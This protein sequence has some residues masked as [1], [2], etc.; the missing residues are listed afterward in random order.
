MADGDIEMP[1][2][3]AWVGTLAVGQE[4]PQSSESHLFQ[5]AGAYGEAS[6]Q[7][8]GLCGSLGSVGAGVLESVDGR[9]A[10]GFRDFVTQLES[11]APGLV[12]A[13]NQL[14]D[15]SDQTAVQ[16]EYTKLM[17]IVQ[18]VLLAL[19]ILHYLF[20]APEAIPAAVTG[21]RAVVLMLLK[22]LV[23]GVAVGTALGV[24]SDVLVQL[25]QFISGHRKQWDAQ[26]TA[27]A[28]ESGAVSGGTSG[29]VFG[30]GRLAAPKFAGSLAGNV[31]H[32]AISG[33][34]SSV[35]MSAID[36]DF[37]DVATW[38]GSFTSGLAGGLEGGKK[39]RFGKGG[40]GSGRVNTDV[41][42]LAGL[43]A[44]GLGLAASG[45]A[46]MDPAGFA[47]K[48]DMFGM[49]S[50]LTASHTATAGTTAR[51]GAGRGA[52]AGAG[53]GRTVGAGAQGT[54]TQGT[55]QVRTSASRGTTPGAGREGGATGAREAVSGI[56]ATA[57]TSGTASSFGAVGVR[58]AA[59]SGAVASVRTT[60][61]TGGGTGTGGGA[62][63]GPGSAATGANRPATT[64]GDAAAAAEQGHTTGTTRAGSAMRTASGPAAAVATSAGS[65]A[66]ATSREA[67][68]AQPR[69]GGTETGATARALQPP[70]AAA[71]VDPVPRP[72]PEAEPVPQSDGG[73]FVPLPASAAVPG[74]VVSHV[75]SFGSQDATGLDAGAAD[76]LRELAAHVARTADLRARTGAPLPEITI[77]GHG[78]S[79]VAGQPHFGQALQLGAERARQTYD[80]LAQH[81]DHH[82]AALGSPLRAD[83]L[84]IHQRSLGPALPHGTD[85]AHDTPQARRRTVITLTHTADDNPPP[86]RTTPLSIENDLPERVN[87]HLTDHLS[88]EPVPDERA[89]E[90][91]R[92]LHRTAGPAF[93]RMDFTARAEAVARHLAKIEFSGTKGGAR[94]EALGR[95]A[96]EG[97]SGSAGASG[98]RRPA[99][100]PPASHLLPVGEQLDRRRPPEVDHGAPPPPVVTGAVRFSDG[101]RIPAYMTG[102]LSEQIGAD[103][104]ALGAGQHEV[105]GADLAVAELADWFGRVAGVRPAHPE[106][107]LDL[108]GRGLR[109]DLREFLGEVKSFPYRTADGLPVHL[110]LTA[111]S[112]GN[113]ERFTFGL[114]SPTKLDVMQRSSA[115]SGRV[116]VNGT[117]WGIAPTLPLALA[118]LPAGGWGRAYL[119]FSFSKQARF[120]LQ[121]QLTNQ[122]ETRSTDGA[123]V[124][125]DDLG[126]EFH[127]VDRLGRPLGADGTPIAE[128]STDR[129]PERLRFAV[130]DGLMARL[131]ASLTSAAPE[132][133]SGFPGT[134]AMSGRTRFREAVVEAIG[135][136]RHIRDGALELAG[137][138]AG[139]KGAGPI[140][141]F[142]SVPNLQSVMRSLYQGP[143]P[144][145]Y[146][147]RNRAEPRGVL[148][149]HA[150]P[151]E[152]VRLSDTTAAEMRDIVTSMLRNEQTLGKS[153]GTEVGGSAGPGF[154]L[155]HL[156]A[157]FNLRVLA[158]VNMRYGVSHTRSAVFGGSGSVK[159]GAQAKG[160][161]TGLYLVRQR[162]TVTG[163]ARGPE[164]RG[165]PLLSPSAPRELPRTETYE[166]WA[167]VR[168]TRSEADR[169]A[170]QPLPRPEGPEPAPLAVTQ[171]MLTL[172]RVQELTF[173][174]GSASRLVDGRPVS[175]P[176]YFSDAVL[177][178]IRSAYPDL[179]APLEE[180]YPGNPRW[181]NSGHFETVLHNTLEVH[182][183]LSYQNMAANLGAMAD[184]GLRIDLIESHRLTRGHRQVWVDATLTQ[185]RYEG[186]QQD[187]RIRFSAPGS[188]NLSGQQSSARSV[189]VG[190]EGVASVRD[191]TPGVA[192]NPL[193]AG[194]VSVGGRYGTG[195]E[196]E[197]GYGSSVG[198]E[199]TSIGTGG[200][201][202]FSYDVSFRVRRDGYWRLRGWLR[203][204]LSAQLLG[205]QPFVFTERR[206][207]LAVT[208]AAGAG[209]PDEPAQGRVVVSVPVGLTRT[210]VADHVLEQPR[211]EAM[212]AEDARDMALLTPRWLERSAAGLDGP[213]AGLADSVL[214]HPHATVAVTDGETLA[215]VTQEVVA[216]ASGGSW[217]V[218]QPGAPGHEAVLRSVGYQGRI[219]NFEANAAPLGSRTKLFTPA[220]YLPRTTRVAQRSALMPGLTALTPVLRMEVEDTVGGAMQ[221]SGRN[222][223]TTTVTFGGQVNGMQSVAAGTGVVSTDGLAL[224]P[225]R[226]DRTAVGAVLRSAS[227]EINRKD[228]GGHQVVVTAPVRHEIAVASS[229]VGAGA[230]EGGLV[231]RS[232]AGVS[233]RTLV[234]PA[235]WVGVIPEKSAH[236]LG[237]ITDGFGDVPRYNDVVPWTPYP[238]LN[239]RPFGGWPAT[240]LN[241]A[242]ALHEFGTRLHGLG[243]SDT[244]LE[245]LRRLVSGRAVRALSNELVGRGMSAPARISR[246]EHLRLGSRQVRLRAELV[247]A[248]VVRLEGLGHSVELEEHRHATET[249]LQGRSRAS[250]T[251]ATLT[252]VEGASTG[253]ALARTAGPAVSHTGASMTTTSVTQ[254]DSTVFGSTVTS[255]EVHAVY[256]TRYDLRLELEITDAGP[257]RPADA[258]GARGRDEWWRSWVVRTRHSV[259]VGRNAGTLTWH[260]PLS[261][262]WAGQDP[263]APGDDPLSPRQLALPPGSGPR[264]LARLPETGARGWQAVPHPDGADRPFEMPEEGFAVRGIAVGLGALDTANTLVLAAAQDLSLVLPDGGEIGEDLLARA[265][266]TPLTR[267]G[268]GPAQS[269]TDG[270]S[271]TAL[272]AF[273]QQT[274]TPQGYRV[275]GLTHRGFFGGVDGSLTLYSRP[276]FSGARLLAVADGV[277]FETPKRQAHGSGSAVAHTDSFARTLDAGPTV[278]TDIGTT[279]PGGVL[280][281]QVTD[282]ATSTLTLDRLSSV[283]IKPDNVVRAYVF[284]VPMRWLSVAQA[285]HHVQDS[286]M[287][288]LVHSVFGNARRVPQAMETDTLA[289]V[290]V[291]HDVATRLG[292]LTHANHPEPA[293]A[294]WDAVKQANDAFTGADKAY[295]DLRRGGRAADRRTRLTEAGDLAATLEQRD[296]DTVQAVRDARDTLDAALADRDADDAEAAHDEWEELRRDRVPQARERLAAARQA[297]ADEVTAARRALA[298]AQ[299]RMDEVATDLD[300][301]RRRAVALAAELGRVRRGA[302][303]LTA[304]YQLSPEERADLRAS[305]TGE[306][307]AVRF[308]PPRAPELNITAA[309]APKK[310]PAAPAP[311]PDVRLDDVN[312]AHATAPWE[313][314]GEPAGNGWSFDAASDHRLMTMTDDAGRS[315]VFDLH[316][317][318]VGNGGALRMPGAEGD[319]VVGTQPVA[320]N[321]FW[322]AV[323]V[324]GGRPDEAAALARGASASDLPADMRLDPRAVFRVQEL[325]TAVPEL[326]RGTPGLPERVVRDGG[327]LPADVRES[328]TPQQRH[329]LLRANL[330]AARRWDDRTADVAAALAARSGGIEL[331]VVDEDGSYRVHGPADPDSGAIRTRAFVYRRGDV[332]LA[333]VP[334]QGDVLVTG[335][336]DSGSAGGSGSE[337][338]SHVVSFGSQDAT[339]LDTREADGL[340]E[341]AADVA[342]A[343]D[344]RARAGAR[345]P[346]IVITGHGTASV[347]GQ[348]H[349]GRALRLGAERARQTYEVF[350]RHLDEHLTGLG[351]AVRAR[352]LRI[353]QRSLGPALPHGTDPAHDTPQARR[354]TVITL[355][356]TTHE[357]PTLPHSTP[358]SVENDLPERVNRHLTNHLSTDPVTGEQAIEAYRELERTGGPAFT[359]LDFRA[360]AEAV[361]RH[362]AKIEF[363]GVKGGAD[364]ASAQR[365][366]QDA[367][368]ILDTAQVMTALKDRGWAPKW[369]VVDGAR[370][371]STVYTSLDSLAAELGFPRAQQSVGTSAPGGAASTVPAATTSARVR[372]P[373]PARSTGLTTAGQQSGPS[374][375]HQPGPSTGRPQVPPKPRH[376]ISPARQSDPAADRQQA[377]S[378]PAPRD[379]PV[380]PPP[381]VEVR[382]RE[383]AERIRWEDFAANSAQARVELAEQGQAP[384]RYLRPRANG[385]LE[386]GAFTRIAGSV[387]I[388]NRSQLVP[389]LIRQ[390]YSCLEWTGRAPIAVFTHEAQGKGDLMLGVKTADALRE[391]FPRNE[392]NRNDI[393]LLTAEPAR[394]KEPDLFRNSGHPFVALDGVKP[395]AP[396]LG[397][398]VAPTHVIV[399]PQ[400]AVTKDFQQSVG[401]WGSTI[402]AMTEYSK[403]DPLPP[404]AAGTG[405]TTGLGADEVGITFDAGLREYRQRQSRIA[406]AGGR[407][408]ARLENLR[409]LESGELRTALFPPEQGRTVDEYAAAPG[410]RLYFAYSNKSA[411]RFALT[412]A[413]VENGESNDVHVVQSSPGPMPTDLDNAVKGTLAGL[414][415]ARV[416]L[417]SISSKSSPQVTVTVTEQTTGGTGKTMHWI[418]TDRVP[419]DDMLTLLK[420]SEPIVMTTGNQST[421]EALSAGKTIMYESIGM[422][423][424]IAFRES[425]YSS[426]GVK[427][428]DIDSLAAV[429]RDY[430]KT[431]ARPGQPEFK[432]AAAVLKRLQQENLMGAFSDQAAAT[433]DL[434][435]WI[436]GQHLRDLLMETGLRPTL[437]QW[438]QALAANPRDPAA[439]RS[440]VAHLLG[441]PDGN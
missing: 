51:A 298:A 294:A 35:A 89:I 373:V 188:E 41:P 301:L 23:E 433:R 169:L 163:P 238:W 232:L 126:Y 97:P 28:A 297:A 399:A 388:R 144:V 225:F 349:F 370:T 10:E 26:A 248:E 363:S 379:H 236:Q 105:R 245:Q 310:A 96:E 400:L 375:G 412:V 161:P 14:G 55:G 114:G 250:G 323:A 282:S 120:N 178:E 369:T 416:R 132:T 190:L 411:L 326:L 241:P 63:T 350:A 79:S 209:G 341:L 267:A 410:S 244:D 268:T 131:A 25:M 158:G 344:L 95:V 70:A 357:P 87:R 157:A 351:S 223:R 409:A 160:T 86:P 34:V 306:P 384:G 437:L 155:A 299:A 84:S 142:F 150:E 429:S 320:G 419:H 193:D 5:L 398:R 263:A 355:T 191:K 290:W 1:P 110:R 358:L 292:L 32:S 202:I 119:Q 27:S 276:D 200:S 29:A 72:V 269:L 332:Y 201:H 192:G 174:D 136:V 88:A 61:G 44:A 164:H 235:G 197:S 404:E 11:L 387:N 390:L 109:G 333:A 367:Q 261:L 151:T 402:S 224:T 300:T 50:A 143:T 336:S 361:A 183:A 342:R 303:R 216:E 302:D 247:P 422:R 170:G 47:G 243:L 391:H 129:E 40:S 215:R 222:A 371:R 9:I 284:A 156:A 264:R 423:Q 217:L 329:A 3:L 108:V 104:T 242:L 177:R 68:A 37:G 256:E 187:L 228:V 288:G 396:P 101:A 4:W 117:S 286:A 360:R 130:R 219:A 280:A 54:E 103:A 254:S 405:Y 316:R 168:L 291:R 77:T 30:A 381:P 380:A 368:R 185:P 436:G 270:T 180:L 85:P 198:S 125:L 218:T 340:R 36:G 153:R 315:H 115:G 266:D 338:V 152:L 116:A 365:D 166:T 80:V 227:A 372:P 401:A 345:L 15:L 211:V 293:R 308:V 229:R 205:A 17:I 281:G 112:Y 318:E 139:S 331:T 271:D 287:V 127:V 277:K 253:D 18:L 418:T 415:V 67:A 420:A 213:A 272:T 366:S 296:T 337:A 258:G 106:V 234:Q 425:L 167:V 22:S 71:G 171:Q 339:G 24:A 383:V 317:P 441:L 52:G 149:V 386:D 354:T 273:Y 221:I 82:L 274:L 210:A 182:K 90:A 59:D 279:Q 62:G 322:D 83:N 260:A 159:V 145:P 7:L 240:A 12:Q 304:W 39:F 92:E 321:G 31:V 330:R 262:M 397:T 100:A 76:G 376:F 324:A 65:T 184:G 43:A 283:N 353:H 421:S 226:L 75:V 206:S 94:P 98:S 343:A 176:E 356:H 328:L 403:K 128:G 439:Y 428:P 295:W 46:T 385:A 231:P 124:H 265:K 91:Y 364:S 285:H 122:T 374:S 278:A 141:D 137:I 347:A 430:D 133:G 438:E 60:S 181:R 113:W 147:G 424:S 135:P 207:E 118:G 427:Q 121:N 389:R 233:G 73:A 413:E 58:G 196:S 230:Y 249:V 56:T 305:G 208:R 16:V 172:S 111:R 189:Q 20:F 45:A 319:G 334:R 19:Q 123:H 314:Q 199:A 440:F 2:E 162:V 146:G 408:V 309:P 346:E 382:Q 352:D 275:A 377:S 237:A 179:V 175:Y 417:V 134:I 431:G 259:V 252:L 194:T 348:P 66:T 435:R 289:L 6:R 394:V 48:Q 204:A 21:A 434:G 426:A 107:L 78:T 251:M 393:V 220:P 148:W 407:R 246:W 49:K 325:A 212:R 313:R 13:A 239:Q 64:S 102:E 8:A 257:S 395:V 359:R 414:G 362:L 203:G 311:R 99:A 53:A 307:D 173:R 327:H 432:A 74:P 195:V 81:L 154:N 312:R 165:L 57:T 33:V 186:L 392:A 406:D 138:P 255:T 69:T 42:S 335:R 214:A 140:T 378:A 38:I 93:T